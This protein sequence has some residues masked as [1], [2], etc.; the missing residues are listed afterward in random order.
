MLFCYRLRCAWDAARRGQA[1]TRPARARPLQAPQAT[2]RRRPAREGASRHRSPRSA[3]CPAPSAPAPPPRSLAATFS[4]SPSSPSW[5]SWRAKLTDLLDDNTRQPSG[6]LVPARTRGFGVRVGAFRYCS[7]SFFSLPC[8]SRFSSAFGYE[9]E[10]NLI[11]S[12]ELE[13]LLRFT[14]GVMIRTDSIT[15]ASSE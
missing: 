5:R 10:P 11:A 1:A 8:F 3:P 13:I 12:L 4:S 14:T 15:V 6:V 2:R 7:C 9:Y